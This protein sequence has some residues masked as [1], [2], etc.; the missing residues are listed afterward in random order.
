M[1]KI[2]VLSLLIISGQMNIIPFSCSY[3]PGWKLSV[4]SFLES[5]YPNVIYLAQHFQVNLCTN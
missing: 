2:S 4:P 1:S 5:P 3:I